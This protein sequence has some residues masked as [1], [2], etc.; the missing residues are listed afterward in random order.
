MDYG[1]AMLEE[2]KKVRNTEELRK[3]PLFFIAHSF[4]GIIMAHCLVKAVQTDEDDHPTIA[5]L[6]RATY[7]MLLFGIPHTGLVVDDIQKMVAGQDNHPRGALLEQIR[8]KS[9]LLAFQL[10]DFKNLIRDRK[11]DSKSKSWARTGG[12]ITAVDNDSALLQLPDSIEEKVPL[13]ADHSMI[14]KFDTNDSRGYTSARDRLVQFERDAPSVVAA[15]FSRSDKSVRLF[16]VQPSV[17][18]VSRVEH[19]VGR[20][21]NITEICEALQYDG[22]RKT[23]VVHGLGGMGKTQLALAYEKRHRDEYSAVF[24]VNSKDVDTLKQGYAAAARRI[25]REHPS[26]VHFKAV[27]EG[28]DLDEAAEAVKRWLSSAGNDRWLVIYDNHDTPG[29]FD[30][31]PFLPEADHGAILITTRSSQLQLGRP[32]AVKKLQNIK[33]SLE[34]LSQT[35]RRDGLS[36]D[37]DAR[38]LADE[39]DGLPLALAT[40]G[41]YLH[42]V[43]DSFAEYLQSYKESWAQLQQD[44]PQLLSYEDRALYSTWN[45]SLNHVKQQSSLAAKLLQLWA[46]FDNQDVWLQ[47]LQEGRGNAPEWFCELTRDRLV[48]NKAR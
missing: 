9:D 22:S 33:H 39:L 41:A 48:F 47:L 24:W 30:I 44:T 18:E 35:S 29:T 37:A 6:H 1:R 12:Y 36:L 34:I 23:A 4:G 28:S 8:S 13:D 3:R 38:K 17:S 20:E 19:F 42:L 27:A 43:P 2:L 21:E 15:R 26:L 25:Y 7:G 16:T 14:V 5:S 31:R 32:V 45:I 10:A 46:Y 40:A 11:V